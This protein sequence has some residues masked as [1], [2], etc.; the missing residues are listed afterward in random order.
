M[1]ALNQI[2]IFTVIDIRKTG[3]QIYGKIVE[4]L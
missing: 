3:R 2:V 4:E 1:K